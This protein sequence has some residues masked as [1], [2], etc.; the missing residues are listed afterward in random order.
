MTALFIPTDPTAVIYLNA[1]D[2]GPDPRN[3]IHRLEGPQ[4]QAAL[5]RRSS[6]SAGR[7]GTTPAPVRHDRQYRKYYEPF[8]GAG[9]Q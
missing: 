2:G 3:D 5:L 9:H 1:T 4:R 8:T 6:V 7:E